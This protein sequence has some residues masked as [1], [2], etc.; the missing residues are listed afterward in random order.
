[1]TYTISINLVLIFDEKSPNI[2]QITT[3]YFC[4]VFEITVWQ[5]DHHQFQCGL[6]MFPIMLILTRGRLKTETQVFFTIRRQS[7]AL[8]FYRNRQL[9]LYASKAATRLTLRQL[10]RPLNVKRVIFD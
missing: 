7:T 10:V 5:H 8:H 2:G 4:T 6:P 9:E 1:M 3:K